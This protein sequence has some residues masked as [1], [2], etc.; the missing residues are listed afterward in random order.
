MK[1]LLPLLL[2]CGCAKTE[3]V[4][5]RF[6]ATVAEAVAAPPS[7]LEVKAGQERLP[8]KVVPVWIQRGLVPEEILGALPDERRATGDE[9]AKALA[10]IDCRAEPMGAYTDGMPAYRSD[11][12]VEV[13]A[14]PGLGLTAKRAFTGKVPP[15]VQTEGRFV[16]TTPP[17]YAAIADWLRVLPL[18]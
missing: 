2:L 15:Q 11:C 13:R 16:S 8:G 5:P 14:I 1:R 12:T 6:T 9:D 17:D 7:S 10:R 4:A 18:K 3:A